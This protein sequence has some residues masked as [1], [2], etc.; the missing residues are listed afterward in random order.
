[1]RL[2]LLDCFQRFE[3]GG[4]LWLR[5]LLCLGLKALLKLPDAARGELLRFTG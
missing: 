4:L 2:D 3:L 1:L 5:R